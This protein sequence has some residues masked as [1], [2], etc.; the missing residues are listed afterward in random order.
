MSFIRALALFAA[1][2]VG[3]AA[4]AAPTRNQSKPTIILVHGAFA[5]GSSWNK[6]IPLLQSRGYSVI[7]VQNPLT[8]LADDSAAVKRAIDNVQGDVVLVGHSWGGMVISQAGDDAKVKALVYVAAFAPDIGQAVMDLGTN[9]A[10]SPGL[11]GVQP[12]ANGYFVLSQQSIAQNFVQDLPAKQAAVIYA[13][14]GPWAAKSLQDKATAAAWKDKPDFYIVA[15]RDR[16]IQPDLERQF[17]QGMNATTTELNTGHVP[18]LTKPASVAKVIIAAADAAE[19]PAQTQPPVTNQ[20]S[21]PVTPPGQPAPGQPVPQP[22]QPTPQPI[23]TPA[24]PAPVPPPP[25]PAPAPAPAPVPGP[26]PA[27]APGPAPVPT[28]AR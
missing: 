8:S 16:M 5:D 12:D 14:Q 13:T 28:P 1:L 2:L 26:S 23:P 19:Q 9:L 15:K 27:P 10:P 6:V 21:Q 11:T 18:M 22:G 17:A 4:H 7:A 24:P 3:F 20:P 25:A